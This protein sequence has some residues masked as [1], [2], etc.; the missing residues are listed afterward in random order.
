MTDRAGNQRASGGVCT[1]TRIAV[2]D[3]RIGDHLDVRLLRASLA[4][5]AAALAR[6]AKPGAFDAPLMGC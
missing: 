1:N 3:T 2:Q 6:A 5:V 4:C